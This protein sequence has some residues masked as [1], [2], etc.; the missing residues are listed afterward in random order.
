MWSGNGII[1][2]QT[3]RINEGWISQCVYGIDL[4]KR[5]KDKKNY[6]ALHSFFVRNASNTH[7]GMSRLVHMFNQLNE[8]LLASVS[9]WK[10]LQLHIHRH[11][12]YNVCGQHGSVL[13]FAYFPFSERSLWNMA[14]IEVSSSSQSMYS[15]TP[16]DIKWFQPAPF[17]DVPTI[18]LTLSTSAFLI[19]SWPVSWWDHKR[20]T[21]STQGELN[22]PPVQRH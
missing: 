18:D 7:S 10:Q 16:Q 19:R 22:L 6:Y 17:S 21:T 4:C 8:A 13:A 3:P 2:A 15:I 9:H 1:E 11:A 20:K 12:R 14:T 5:E